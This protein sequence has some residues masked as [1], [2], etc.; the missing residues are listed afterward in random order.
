MHEHS[1]IKNLIEKAKDIALKQRGGKILSLKIRL[2]ALSHISADH[3]KEHFNNETPGTVLD[4]ATLVVEE[5]KDTN[6]PL[7]Q[8]IVLESVEFEDVND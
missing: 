1:L 5:Q 2:G 6:D 4:G 8:E 3:F 7:A